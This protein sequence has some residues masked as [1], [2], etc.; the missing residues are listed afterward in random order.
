MA[1]LDLRIQSLSDRQA[2]TR[3]GHVE[4]LIPEANTL[5]AE[6]DQAETA[7]LQAR[8]AAVREFTSRFSR[9]ERARARFPGRQAAEIGR[10]EIVAPAEARLAAAKTTAARARALRD[11]IRAE[12][13]PVEVR[14]SY[15][16]GI[17]GVYNET[18]GKVEWREQFGRGVAGA[19][20]PATRSVRWET[21]FSG[22]DLVR[23]PTTGR[24][25]RGIGVSAV[26][27]YVDPQTNRARFE[28]AVHG[29]A[30]VVDGQGQI[31]RA[32]NVSGSI[33]GWVDPVTGQAKFQSGYF[34]DG[35]A[36]VYRDGDTYRSD[37]SFYDDDG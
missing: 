25:E 11:S 30:V 31:H 8:D 33:V 23:D 27:G 35:A 32:N 26:A 18:S 14:T 13:Q 1:N 16:S 17:C 22:I 15:S 29:H 6:S 24:I 7:A 37:C 12:A 2:A 36:V 28:P 20:D 9:V 21:H 10:A 4:Q 19:Y 3:R 5:A 34:N